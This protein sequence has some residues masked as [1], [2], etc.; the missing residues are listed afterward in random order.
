MIGSAAVEGTGSVTVSQVAL[1]TDS[2]LRRQAQDAPGGEI[3]TSNQPVLELGPEP[4]SL[5]EWLGEM[6]AHRGV[7]FVLARKDFHVRFKRASF[8]V[9]WAVAVP[10]LQAAVM[11]FVFSHFVH[12]TSGV[13]YGAYVLSGILAWSYFLAA[14]PAGVTSI[15]D[16]TGLTDKV[17]FPRAILPLVPCL[18]G[19]VG[20]GISMVLLLI[21]A[22]ILGEGLG[23]R[24]LLLIPAC[25][26][27]VS[28][29]CALCLVTSALQVYFRDVRFII[30]A[31]L[32]MWLYATPIMYP[33][34]VVKGLGPYLDFNP[35]TGVISLFHLAI[36]GPTQ[37]WHRAV[38]VSV[39]TTVVLLVIGIEAQRRRDRVF[40]DLL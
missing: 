17:W 1:T 8:G 18:S 27:L 23:V 5:R 34:R 7:T 29:T 28:F 2:E 35:M 32:M 33:V 39:I 3:G 24:A 13:S 30:S 31:L 11:V 15:V 4:A 12:T 20:L 37:P 16:G 10:A 21:G 36:L 14:L 40:V 9:L 19:L 6:W 26:L 38:I 25:L 22:P